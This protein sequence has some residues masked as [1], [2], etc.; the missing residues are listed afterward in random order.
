MRLV[1][2][3]VF[4]TVLMVSAEVPL[5]SAPPAGRTAATSAKPCE[6][7]AP[8]WAQV[9]GNPLAG[10]DEPVRFYG[11]LAV[12]RRLDSCV[13]PALIHPEEVGG[14][15]KQD[16]NLRRKSGPTLLRPL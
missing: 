1:I 4:A 13:V 16:Q 15:A 9:K 2:V 6:R 8:R 10:P 11:H 5:Q 7:I 3:P 12:L 14:V